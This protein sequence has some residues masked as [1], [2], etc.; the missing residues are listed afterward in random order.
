MRDLTSPKPRYS[1]VM[2]FVRRLVICAVVFALPGLSAAGVAA[3]ATTVP[4]QINSAPF[5]NPAGSFDTFAANC[6]AIV[7]EQS[8]VVVVAGGRGS[9]SS[10]SGRGWGCSVNASVQWINLSTGATGA[11]QTSD[12][13]HGF[14]PEAT[15]RTGVGRVALILNAGGIHTPGFATL[16]VP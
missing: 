6:V 5:G 8:G 11:A 14:P 9:D 13:L 1:P 7:G 15:L 10:E 16:Y 3:A 4:F 2:K 12:G